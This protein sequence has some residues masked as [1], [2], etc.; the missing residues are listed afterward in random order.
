MPGVPLVIK[1]LVPATLLIGSL[2]LL[3][4]FIPPARRNRKTSREGGIHPHVRSRI[5]AFT[6]SKRGTVVPDDGKIRKT[7]TQWKAELTEDQYKVTRRGAT[8]RPFTGQYW[9]NR[10]EG[11]YRCVGCGQGLFASDSKYDAGT[12]WPSYSRPVRADAVDEIMDISYGMVRTEIVCSR[13][14]AHLG[15]VFADGPRP[16][17]RRYCINSASLDFVPASQEN[18]SEKAG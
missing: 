4:N 13:C 8:E 16:T 7:K 6:G 18:P 9:N 10:E 17:G 5:T 14:E 3:A 1:I 15:H 12:G 11:S 2:V